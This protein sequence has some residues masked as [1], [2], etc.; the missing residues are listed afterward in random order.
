[1]CGL[2]VSEN[3]QSWMNILQTS[4][5][6]QLKD[7]QEPIQQATREMQIDLLLF[8]CEIFCVE[9]FFEGTEEKNELFLES[10]SKMWQ[11]TC[12]LAEN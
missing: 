7:E 6:P 11:K 2:C 12:K 8:G 4:G 5:E 9:S 3:I 1:M 10:S